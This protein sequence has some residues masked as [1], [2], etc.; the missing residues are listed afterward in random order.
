MRLGDRIRRQKNEK[1]LIFAK[2]ACQNHINFTMA[3][4]TTEGA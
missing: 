3:I 1:R 2:I 4:Y